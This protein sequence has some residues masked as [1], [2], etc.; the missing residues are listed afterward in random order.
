MRYHATSFRVDINSE[1]FFVDILTLKDGGSS[2]F[3]LRPSRSIN[4]SCRS[5]ARTD[6][7]NLPQVDFTALF[8]VSIV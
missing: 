7:F 8:E 5:A 4:W 3:P 6:V 2:G 1:I